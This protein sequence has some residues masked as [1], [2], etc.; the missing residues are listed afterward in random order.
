M[1]NMVSS[2]VVVFILIMTL[3]GG[4][5]RSVAD[6]RAGPVVST[7]YPVASLDDPQELERFL[8]ALIAERM[9]KY[10]IP[11]ET[12]TVVRDG[13]VIFARGYGYADVDKRIRVDPERTLFRIGSVSKLFV[14]TAVMQLVEQ[15]KLDPNADVNTYLRGASGH[16][17]IRI[18]PTYP[19]PITLAYLLTHTSGFEKQD[20]YSIFP[21]K[22]GWIPLDEYLA[23]RMPERVDPPGQV[24]VYSNYGTSLAA[25]IVQQVSGMPFEEYVERFIYEPLD[26]QHSTFRQPLPARLDG[27]LAAGVKWQPGKG[28]GR[29]VEF[30][31]MH[32]SGAMSSTAVDMARFMIAHLQNGRYEDCEGRSHWI[33]GE[34]TAIDMHSRQFAYDSRLPGFTFGFFEGELD[35][36]RLIY[37]AGGSAAFSA[38]LALAPEQN[39]GVFEAYSG[40]EPGSGFIYPALLAHL[41][42]VAS[43]SGPLPSTVVPETQFV[44]EYLDLNVNHSSPEKLL[45]L[46]KEVSVK[47]T[48]NGRIAFLGGTWIQVEPLVFQEVDSG[49]L[50]VFR[51]KDGTPEGRVTHL[52]RGELAYEKLPWYRR[53]AFHIG[54]LAACLLVF[55]SAALGWPVVSLRRRRHSQKPAPPAPLS[56]WVGC[57]M[58]LA[59]LAFILTFAVE[60]YENDVIFFGLTPAARGIL[61]LPLVGAVLAANTLILTVAGWMEW[62]T[63]ARRSYWDLPGRVPDAL[64]TAAGV[65]FIWWLSYWNLLGF[66]F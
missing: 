17:G 19:E 55:L 61:I 36:T 20:W 2:L 12:V 18:P 59:F 6:E 8:D 27:D 26:M 10:H 46:I 25:Y 45:A 4:C 11:G 58:S 37:H 1:K 48:G 41:F 39:L 23:T 66:R 14:W 35:G 29:Q 21:D 33:L 15:G 3:A 16:A 42:P 24:W 53:T 28:H 34:E 7:A 63:P 38:H 50:A 43:R 56:R 52:I 57:A 47:K 40:G 44:G 62:G 54:L 22:D 5:V 51:T 30:E 9:E 65:A 13:K 32:P 31:W 49:E 60:V 64:L